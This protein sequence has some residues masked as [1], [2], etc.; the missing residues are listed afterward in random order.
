MAVI[1]KSKVAVDK[2]VYDQATAIYDSISRRRKSRFLKQGQLP[3]ILCLVSSKKYPGQFTDKKQE[4]A[5]TNPQIFIYD[6]RVWEIKPEAYTDS[7]WFHVFTGDMTRKPRILQKDEKVP[8]SERP[9]VMAIPAEYKSEFQKDIINALREIAGVSTLARHPFFVE[10]EKV[11]AAFRKRP[12]IFSQ[13]P[14]DFVE[15]KVQLLKQFFY[16]PELPRFAHGDL[17]ISGNS[18]SLAIGCITGFVDINANLDE[19]A[20]LGGGQIVPSTGQ[21]AYMPLIRIDGVLEIRPPKGGEILFWKVREI[22]M[23]L[24]NAGLNIRWVTF[25][26]FQSKDSQQILRQQGFIT[27]QQSIDTVP[28]TAYD[29]TKRAVYEGRLDIPYHPHLRREMVSLEKDPKTG[30]VDHPPQGSKDCSDGLAGV[31]YGLTNRREIWSMFGIPITSAPP[32]IAAALDKL[33]SRED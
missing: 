20:L 32:S 11:N 18:A 26:Q 22:L 25:D 12:S 31:V 10:V 21:A 6:K 27:G 30:K 28:C 2:G 29:L 17:A 14:V 7:E 23:K 3:G 13:S 9:L 19:R 1:E 4:E 8:N 24:R 15:T 5:K 33:S 16:K